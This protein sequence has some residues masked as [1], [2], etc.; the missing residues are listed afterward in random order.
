MTKMSTRRTMN[1][2]RTGG[3]QDQAR[4]GLF[5]LP[6]AAFRASGACG[7]RDGE[8]RA[9]SVFPWP[10]PD[11]GIFSVSLNL[12]A[13]PN[14]RRVSASRRTLSPLTNGNTCAT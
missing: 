5:V 1:R 10:I 6:L 9:A 3:F 14:V 13:A 8:P 7:F 12:G 4:L 2:P 11:P